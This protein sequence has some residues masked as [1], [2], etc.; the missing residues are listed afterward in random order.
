LD[1]VTSNPVSKDRNGV[2]RTSFI[3]GDIIQLDGSGSIGCINR[4]EWSVAAGSAVSARFIDPSNGSYLT[5][6]ATIANPV[7][8]ACDLNTNNNPAGDTAV[9]NCSIG[10]TKTLAIQLKVC[11]NAACNDKTDTKTINITINGL[12]S[13]AT[14]NFVDVAVAKGG[15]RVREA[16]A[17]KD[18]D[19]SGYRWNI[20]TGILDTINLA[21]GGDVVDKGLRRVIVDMDNNVWFAEYPDGN[22]DGDGE[23][24]KWDPFGA[25]VIFDRNLCPNPLGDGINCSYDVGGIYAIKPNPNNQN[26]L[27]LGTDDGYTYIHLNGNDENW[28]CDSLGYIDLLGRTEEGHL[29]YA[30]G[31]DNQGK[32]WIYDA[33]YYTS[34]N[35]QTVD[36]LKV[37]SDAY[38]CSSIRSINV[39]NGV[40]DNISA[41]APGTTNELWI[42]SYSSGNNL[43]IITNT[44]SVSGSTAPNFTTLTP[45]GRLGKYNSVYTDS[46][47]D[48]KRDGDATSN[49]M[50][51]AQVGAICRYVRAAYSGISAYYMCFGDKSV[52]Y[53]AV[54]FY[55]NGFGDRTFYF[56]GS[57]GLFRIK[58]Y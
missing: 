30:I 33:G 5:T 3:P 28:S 8:I 37:Y 51:I 18:G 34:S 48:I 47:Y 27:F 12:E 55:T 10:A 43:N 23:L 49:E 41:I 19:T 22:F 24:I 7:I 16:Y 6:P 11:N 9:S 54:D 35:F 17:T 2:N 46:T 58:D 56:A 50:W 52:T 29:I 42:G 40:M 36:R 38:S 44:S 45:T 1:Y 53:N 32:R 57:T 39:Y 25:K 31:F 15:S 14:G 13:L 26:D 4:Y 20:S 21:V